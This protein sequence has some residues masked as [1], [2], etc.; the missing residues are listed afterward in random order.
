MRVSWGNPATKI[1][2]SGDLFV[3]KSLDHHYDIGVTT[4]RHALTIA[5]PRMG[6]GAGVI[7]PNLLRWPDSALVIDPKGEAAEATAEAREAMGQKVHVLDPFN[8]CDLP[9]RFKAR[10]NPLDEIIPK[11]IGAREDV[12]V[13]ADGLLMKHDPR[14]GHWDGGGK[15][16]I[17]GL[18]AH[19]ASTREGTDRSLMEVRAML[20]LQGDEFDALVDR[21]GE[22]TAFGKLPIEA[23]GKLTKTGKEAV[24]FISVADEN[25]KW[26]NSE[27]MGAIMTDS[28][29]KLSDLK[30]EKC[31]VYLVLPPEYM[32]EHNRF[33]RLFV[34]S[35]INAMAKGGHKNKNR[36]LFL[37]DEF[38]SLGYI[39][40]IGKAA[41]LMPGYGVHLWPILQ[42]L[43]QLYKLYDKDGAQGFI[44][45]ADLLQFFGIS[46]EITPEFVSKRLGATNESEMST[47]PFAP[48]TEINGGLDFFVEGASQHDYTNRKA[49]ADASHQNAMNQWQKEA[50][51]IGKPR[52]TP[53]EVIGLTEKPDGEI[54]ARY[55]VAIIKNQPF[56][57][58]VAAHFINF[59]PAPPAP[60]RPEIIEPLYVKITFALLL[61][62]IWT[63]ELA[64][65]YSFTALI[66]FALTFGLGI[67]QLNGCHESK[68]CNE[69]LGNHVDFLH[70]KPD[71]V[72]GKEK[73]DKP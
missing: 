2:K 7:I 1:Y 13:L 24:H 52:I 54:V 31:T 3:G 9:E 63:W 62:F 66:I 30:S 14:G 6:K 32:E 50:R 4:E 44:G 15:T 12:N 26:L 41:G 27:E 65:E 48:A 67:S 10:F 18:I 39:E 16:L 29:F 68:S 59:A 57:L 38:Y 40:A 64:Q 55:Q 46:D 23:H 47:P 11:A 56:Q 42:D 21:L 25:T 51:E 36:C 33:L 37:L 58:R 71:M 49:H 60:P 53:D 45:G 35:A 28:T 34:R 22:N 72:F 61:P 8:K 70:K 43:G 19:V 73:Y 20:D 69:W 17:A 5:G